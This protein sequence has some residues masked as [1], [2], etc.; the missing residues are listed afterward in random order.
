MPI[1]G[2]CRVTPIVLHQVGRPWSLLTHC[3]LASAALRRHLNGRPPFARARGPSRA[4]NRCAPRS[5]SRSTRPGRR[6]MPRPKLCR[7][8][9]WCRMAAPC[10]V[11]TFSKRWPRP[12]RSCTV[13]MRCSQVAVRSI[14][15]PHGNQCCRPVS[16]TLF[17]QL[18]KRG[19]SSRHVGCLVLVKMYWIDPGGQS[20]RRGCN[21]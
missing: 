11:N 6:K 19:D 21:R 9:S 15:F 7:R 10:P 12:V 18:V 3:R 1:R 8:R 17:R 20:A 14:Q 4:S 2:F 5:N 13:L 16:P